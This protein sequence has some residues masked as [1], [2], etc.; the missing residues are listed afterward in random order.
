[1]RRAVPI[2]GWATVSSSHGAMVTPEQRRGL[3]SSGRVNSHH[4]VLGTG[5]GSLEVSGQA[6]LA[7]GRL[8]GLRGG[9][10]ESEGDVPLLPL[11]HCF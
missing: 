6:R 3:R 9:G 7:W 2:T 11:R 8:G 1:M 10:E 4:V 5:L